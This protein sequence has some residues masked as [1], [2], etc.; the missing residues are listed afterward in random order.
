MCFS[1][2]ASFAASAIIGATGIAA[3]KKAKTKKELPLAIIPLLFAIQQF[4]E[5]TV[6]LNPSSSLTGKIAMYSFMFF[7]FV[8]WPSYMPLAARLIEPDKNRKKILA[9]I[10]TAGIFVSLYLLY[11]LI[12]HPIA[13]EVLNNHIR[14]FT[15]DK[16]TQEPYY[17]A[18]YGIVTVG[19]CLISS[20]K[21]INI[22]GIGLLLSFLASLH[23]YFSN[24]GSVWCFFAAALSLVIYLH[25][26]YNKR[27]SNPK[28]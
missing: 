25:F 26:Q 19:S 8:I 24:Y 9:I 18:I 13:Y 27:N 4:M 5:G 28:P 20:H 14:Y 10:L 7:A 11:S 3:T 17:L 23:F 2:P 6:W 16:T 1:A 22:Y 15:L 21:W 12:A